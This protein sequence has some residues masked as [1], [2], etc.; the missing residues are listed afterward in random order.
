MNV[1]DN[2]SG[3]IIFGFFIIMN[4]IKLLFFELVLYNLGLIQSFSPKSRGS[5]FVIH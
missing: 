4:Y 2:A 3:I 1:G 5:S